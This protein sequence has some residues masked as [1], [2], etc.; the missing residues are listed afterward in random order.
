M[1]SILHTTYKKDIVPTLKEKFGYSN[2]M[3]VPK[4]ARVVINVGFGRHAK[5]NSFIEGVEKTLSKITG[6]KPVRNKA[7]KS[8]SNFKIRE[9]MN[10]GASV[11]LRGDNMYE[12]LYKLINLTLPRVRD[13]RGLNPKSF[14][15]NGNYTIGFKENLAFP[16][17]SSESSD[18]VHGLEITVSTSAK[19]AEEGKALLEAIGFPFR[20]K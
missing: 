11:S 8:I 19:N 7:K 16:E 12:F 1:A 6:Q 4:I 9:G 10:V 2:I 17:M 3:Q 15:K 13:F 14:D 20:K 18:S 5:D